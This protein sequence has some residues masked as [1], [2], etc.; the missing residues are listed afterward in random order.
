MIDT[1]DDGQLAHIRFSCRVNE[2]T[3]DR[4]RDAMEKKLA[5]GIKRFVLSMCTT[6]GDW[7]PAFEAHRYLKRSGAEIITH[8]YYFVGSAAIIIFCAGTQRTCVRKGQF[9]FHPALIRE[10]GRSIVTQE[11]V[12]K[13]DR[14]IA[15]VI[16][17]SCGQDDDDALLV[18]KENCKFNSEE[19]L[20]FGLVDRIQDTL[21]TKGTREVQIEDTL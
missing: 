9:K 14:R 19:A 16:A 20:D 18:I 5:K 7:D 2:H 3:I 6:G 21:G 15:R 1:T 12:D 17:E 11:E 13:Y 8:N 4:L 10:E